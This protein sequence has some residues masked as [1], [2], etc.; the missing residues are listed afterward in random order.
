MM[1]KQ[2]VITKCKK[3]AAQLRSVFERNKVKNIEVVYYMGH[4][5]IR[6]STRTGV[7]NC[8]SFLGILFDEVRVVG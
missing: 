7:K 3:L 2:T 1:Q 4:V 6:F 5:S 8:L